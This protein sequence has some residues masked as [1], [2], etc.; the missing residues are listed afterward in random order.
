MS[1]NGEELWGPVY[2]KTF[3]KEVLQLQN[4]IANEVRLFPA[5]M[6]PINFFYVPWPKLSHF[7]YYAIK[8]VIYYHSNDCTA[9]Y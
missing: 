1:P 5:F 8:D 7:F 2:N 9:W 4:H 6:L 3:L